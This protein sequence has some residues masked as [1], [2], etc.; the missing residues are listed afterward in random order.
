M[1]TNI[2]TTFFIKMNVITRC[3]RLYSRKNNFNR[4]LYIN[5]L[6][7]AS[8]LSK[9]YSCYTFS[10]CK[11]KTKLLLY[12]RYNL[13]NSCFQQLLD[14]GW[15]QPTNKKTYFRF[16]YQAEMLV[17]DFDRDLKQLLKSVDEGTIKQIMK[18]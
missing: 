2:D 8:L 10:W 17:R 18:G 14:S 12:Y 13:L 3:M 4:T 11:V 7:T 15:I 1:E 6:Y 16:S 5:I 9:N